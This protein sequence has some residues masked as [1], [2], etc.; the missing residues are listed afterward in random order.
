MTRLWLCLRFPF[1]VLL[2]AFSFSSPGPAV[3]TTM[4][5]LGLSDLC[6]IADIVAE[7][8]VVAFLRSSGVSAEPYGR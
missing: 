3:A 2:C 7:A 1:F 5:E 6:W 8:E 4:V